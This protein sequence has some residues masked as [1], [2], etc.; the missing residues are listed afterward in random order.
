MVPV[1]FG[2]TIIAFFLL[3]LI[4]GDPTIV[5]LGTHWTPARAA[6]LQHEIGLDKSLWDQYFLFL[7]HLVHFN[8]G[9]SVFYRLPVATLIQQRLSVTLW[10]VLY[11]ETLALL[12]SVPLATFTALR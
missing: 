6:V 4:P 3:R 2:I 9:Q 10:L 1:V 7:N 12:I 5:M 11:S 8:L